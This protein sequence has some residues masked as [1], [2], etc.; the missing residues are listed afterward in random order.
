MILCCRGRWA[1]PPRWQRR[2]I[3]RSCGGDWFSWKESE[4]WPQEIRENS[5]VRPLNTLLIIQSH[6]VDRIKLGFWH[7]SVGNKVSVTHFSWLSIFI[8]DLK[9]IYLVEVAATVDKKKLPNDW[10]K[11]GG[12]KVRFKINGSA[13]LLQLF[14]SFRPRVVM[15]LDL[16]KNV[17]DSSKRRRRT[18]PQPSNRLNS[19]FTLSLTQTAPCGCELF[20]FLPNSIA[21]SVWQRRRRRSENLHADLFSLKETRPS[22]TLRN[23]DIQLF[24]WARI[25]R[26]SYPT[27]WSSG[28]MLVKLF[29]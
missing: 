9:E 26:A 19:A 25:W 13:R 17:S 18:V 23:F 6:T 3:R 11:S 7:S 5:W 1:C 20:G 15:L 10:T 22:W 29:C 16:C 28:Q 21:Y 24:A 2:E 4:C 12:T 14:R 27:M 8:Q